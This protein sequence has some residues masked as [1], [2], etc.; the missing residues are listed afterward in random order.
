MGRRT[1]KEGIISSS[2]LS[3]RQCTWWA[4][5]ETHCIQE[6]LMLSCSTANVHQRQACKVKVTW[7]PAEASVSA[8]SIDIYMIINTML[9]T[10]ILMTSV[11][12]CASVKSS[13]FY[14]LK[15]DG[16][17]NSGL[18]LFKWGKYFAHVKCPWYRYQ[19][20][21]QT[22]TDEFSPKRMSETPC[23][24]EVM[25]VGLWRGNRLRS[26][27]GEKETEFTCPDF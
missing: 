6:A 18:H 16:R 2:S 5:G 20:V 21:F 11:S 27:Q 4:T 13:F 8:S 10:G 1:T 12:S 19:N 9:D 7:R 26:K 17:H 25:S 14:P 15:S 24:L 3:N 23:S 22:V